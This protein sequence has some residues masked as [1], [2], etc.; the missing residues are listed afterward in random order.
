MTRDTFARAARPFLIVYGALAIGCLAVA[1]VC[2]WPLIALAAFTAWGWK[3]VP[4]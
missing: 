2:P 3:D 1:P 4:R